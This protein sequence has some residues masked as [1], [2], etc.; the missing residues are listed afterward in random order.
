MVE[1]LVVL[2]FSVMLL[3][4][5]YP[6]DEI[7]AGAT[8][9]SQSA[10]QQLA[11]AIKKYHRSYSYAMAIAYIPNCA[12]T[13]SY[14]VNKAATELWSGAD[15]F[16]LGTLGVSFDRCIDWLN[17]QIPTPSFSATG[18]SIDFKN[19]FESIVKDMVTNAIKSA[20]DSFS[21]GDILK[22][23]IGF[24]PIELIFG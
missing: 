4:R 22:G 3:T 18:F 1:Y 2:A 10:V 13:Y 5:P 11:D 12:Y 8:G 14:D 9:T 24:D 17:P 7:V 16:G 19:D 20:V 6:A 21:P 23:F 15:A